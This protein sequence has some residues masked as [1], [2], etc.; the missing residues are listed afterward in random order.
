MAVQDEDAEDEDALAGGEDEVESQHDLVG[1]S[2]G[3]A[4]LRGSQPPDSQ[5]EVSDH[6]ADQQEE[7]DGVTEYLGETSLTSTTTVAQLAARL[8]GRSQLQQ[9][10]IPPPAMMTLVL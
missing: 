5:G 4:R 2:V 1:P 10:L 7:E 9:G 3:L 6:G 8:A